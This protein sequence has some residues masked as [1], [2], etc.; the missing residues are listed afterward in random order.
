MTQ[1]SDRFTVKP[2]K[3]ARF[4]QMNRESRLRLKKFRIKISH[5]QSARHAEHFVFNALKEAS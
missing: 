2:T 3:E 1:R 5:R 4:A